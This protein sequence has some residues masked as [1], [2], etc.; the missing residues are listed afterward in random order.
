MTQSPTWIATARLLRRTGF[1]TTGT[2]VDAVVGQDWSTY[3]DAALA[4]DPESDPGAVATPMPSVIMPTF[5]SPDASQAVND[6]F[7]TGLLVQMGDLVSWWIRRMA[8]VQQPIHEKLTLLWH[9]HFATSA[10]QG[11][12]R[13]DHGRAE[14]RNCAASSSATS[15]P[16]P[17]RC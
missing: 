10:V 6:A 4:A 9:N 8:A 15:T 14:R 13:R 17:T 12:G 2:E 7:M 5:P 11:A 1:G 16:W 3:L